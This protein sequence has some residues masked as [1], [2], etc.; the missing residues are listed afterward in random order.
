MSENKIRCSVAM[1]THNSERFIVEQIDTILMNMGP[2]DELVISDDYSSDSTHSIVEGYCQKDHRIRFIKSDRPLGVNANFVRAYQ[3]CRG[4][5]IFHSDDD[6]VWLPDK[7]NTVLPHFDDPKIYLVMHDA[8]I[9]DERLQ[10]LHPSFYAWR[11]SKPGV[12]HNL[13]KLSYGG[14]MIAFRKELLDKALKGPKDLPMFFDAWLGFMADKHYRSLF[15][16]DTL[17]FWRRHEGTSSGDS[18]LQEGVKKKKK[19]GTRIWPRIKM[20]WAVITH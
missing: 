8:K 2:D 7:I 6:N 4:S 5:I 19:K 14:S 18:F 3:H 16:P 11:N 9:V 17:S 10:E 12:I 1:L 15:I 13:I 20:L